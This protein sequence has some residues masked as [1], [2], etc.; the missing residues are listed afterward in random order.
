MRFA[1]ELMRRSGVADGKTSKQI[2]VLDR[3]VTHMVRIID[4]LLDVSRIT[5]GKLELRKEPVSL[6]NA[7]HGA[8]EL[9][10]P[11]LEAAQHVLKVS[12]PTE[13]IMLLADPVRLTQMIVNILNNAVKFTPP[14][15]HIYVVAETLGDIA[16]HPAQVRLRVRDDGIGIAPELRPRIFDMFTQGDRS[17]ERTR[18][19]LGV[20]LTLVRNLAHLHDGR[21]DIRS[22]GVDAG[23][24]VIIDLPVA[25]P[26]TAMESTPETAPSK[27]SRPLRILVADDNEDG[28]EMLRFFLEADGH[29]VATAEDGASA[30][31]AAADFHPDV[32]ILDVGMPRLN[33]YAAA[34]QL[35]AAHGPESL[36]LIAL[37]GLG[38]E[39]DKRRA[40]QAG[41]D[42]HFTK[43]V[44]IPA[45]TK[46]LTS[47]SDRRSSER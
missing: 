20:G 14:G 13:P 5:Q 17:L 47:F 30:V 41:F 15:G 1:L 44:D 18:G 24:E 31:A 38:Q 3:Q 39:E 29:T 9:C 26:A 27:P 40:A 34:Q 7:V 33:G 37:S 32:A 35:R 25:P 4:D 2:Q 16:G 42:V 43:P 22:D 19:G 6:A 45:L 46:A 36:A 23:T 21:V 28:R 12:L 10:R 8:I 11:A